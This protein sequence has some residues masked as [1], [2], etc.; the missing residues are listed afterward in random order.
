MN[1]LSK[2]RMGSA[3]PESIVEQSLFISLHTSHAS[4]LPDSLRSHPNVGHHGDFSS[5]NRFDSSAL[6]TA[7]TY[8]IVRT[9]CWLLR[10]PSDC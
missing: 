5:A 4:K 2:L 3:L 8:A 9:L 10:T 1:E 7:G 6:I